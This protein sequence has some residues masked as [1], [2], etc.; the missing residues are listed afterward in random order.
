MN[1]LPRLAFALG[2][3]ACFSLATA[4]DDGAG[5]IAL[6]NGKNLDGWVIENNGQFSVADGMLRVN[7]GTGW[8]RSVDTFADFTLVLE[9]RFLEPRANSGIFVRTASTSRDDANGWPDNG[10]QVQCMDIFE[11][12]HPLGTLI[13]YGA[14]PYESQIDREALARATKPTGEWHREEI[15]CRG[16]TV[17]IVLNGETVERATNV[18][19][20]S[21]HVGIQ[22]EHGLLEFRTIAIKRL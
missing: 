14:P 4:A 3:L 22:G 1:P 10:Y 8:L 15:T 12:D 9:F 6:F 16:E 17:T 19:N 11:G 20:L 18:K 2:Y 13:L 7:E 5:E 21:G